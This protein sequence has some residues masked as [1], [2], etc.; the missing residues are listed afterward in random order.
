MPLPTFKE[1]Q[2]IFPPSE[3][4]RK[5]TY[6]ELLNLY[7]NIRKLKP[8]PST[9][10][11]LMQSYLNSLK[12]TFKGGGCYDNI[13]LD[14]LKL[15]ELPEIMK[16]YP[17][18]EIYAMEE[19]QK[20]KALKSH[21]AIFGMQ[22]PMVRNCTALLKFFLFLLSTVGIR[23]Y[24]C[25][26]FDQSEYDVWQ[27]LE[28]HFDK[29]VLLNKQISDYESYTFEN[30]MSILALI[31]Q[32]DSIPTVFHC[33]AGYGRT[34]TVMYMILLYYKAK[35]NP[36]VLRRQ[37]YTKTELLTHVEIEQT[38]LA[39]EYSFESAEEFY[40]ER[41]LLRAQVMNMANNA[42]AHTLTLY[43]PMYK[44][45]AYTQYDSFFDLTKQ[46]LHFTEKLSEA[47][48]TD[49]IILA[50]ENSSSEQISS[51][52]HN[53]TVEQNIIV[54]G[55]HIPLSGSV[56]FSIGN[57]NF[58]GEVH[59]FLKNDKGDLE[60]VSIFCSY[61]ETGLDVEKF[62]KDEV[63]IFVYF[64]DSNL[65]Y[66]IDHYLNNLLSIE[67]EKEL[68]RKFKFDYHHA[69]ITDEEDIVENLYLDS[70]GK[71]VRTEYYISNGIFRTII[72]FEPRFKYTRDVDG[73]S[74]RKKKKKSR[75]NKRRR[76]AQKS[77]RR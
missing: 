19:Y 34:G 60:G 63:E 68:K 6:E 57:K 77:R 55:I 13:D 14:K 5:Y 28:R 41:Y 74:S 53:E 37:L 54:L 9:S 24:I 32:N 7:K 44:N 49:I 56:K 66:D 12:K 1:L 42:I 22:N 36:N 8:D 59:E 35:K 61:I 31:E 64:T 10:K 21:P 39:K 45:I 72:P 27:V 67:K 75:R 25:L 50:Q 4:S 17:P 70:N 47:E 58:Y 69:Q 33:T 43:Y 11:Q 30:A 15:L 48:S 65:N 18:E 46:S 20:L 62:E 73:G 51:T 23:R 16:M 29:A 40:N 71:K 38:D 52:Q 76:S 3:A 26:A 2:E